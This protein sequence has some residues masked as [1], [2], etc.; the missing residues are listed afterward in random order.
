MA[1]TTPRTWVTNELVTATLMNAHVRDNLAYLLTPNSFQARVGSGTYTTSSTSVVSVDA[2]FNET[3]T[4]YGGHVLLLAQGCM[5]ITTPGTYTAT[6]YFDI[7]GTDREMWICRSN[8]AT[9]VDGFFS[10]FYL[11]ENLAA[12]SHTFKLQWKVSNG[13]ETATLTNSQ[14]ALTF[15]GIEI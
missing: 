1:W 12:G 5:S 7:D 14:V 15:S 8:V 13:A 6:L 2:A 10:V 11:E 4:T 3:I 9:T